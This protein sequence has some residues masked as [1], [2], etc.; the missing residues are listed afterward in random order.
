MKNRVLNIIMIIGVAFA[1]ASCSHNNPNHGEFNANPKEGYISF[2]ESVKTPVISSATED[3]AFGIVNNTPILDDEDIEVTYEVTLDSTSTISTSP[4]EI[5]D[6][7]TGTAIIPAGEDAGAFEIA[8]NNNSALEDIIE[9]IDE[10]P[11]NNIYNLN[12]SLTS[13]NPDRYT[14]DKDLNGE[15]IVSATAGLACEVDVQENYY[16]ATEL[17]ADMFQDPSEIPG[18][19]AAIDLKEVVFEEIDE[20]TYRVEDALYQD[21]VAELTGEEDDAG[22]VADLILTIDDVTGDVDVEV[23]STS[24]QY[25]APL[26]GDVEGTYD[27]CTDRLEIEFDQQL[28]QGDVPM[29][30]VFGQEDSFSEEEDALTEEDF[31]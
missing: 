3:L 11:E 8:V 10:D 12:V 22:V 6:D 26:I 1:I 18:D 29:R 20:Y 5:I 31:E 19:W 23:E 14:V 9:E 4:S 16:A 2:N 17:G 28:F 24:H 21:I 27:S 30:L 25:A 15:L 7:L 13:A